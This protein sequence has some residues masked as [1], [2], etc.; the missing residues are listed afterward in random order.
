MRAHGLV[1]DVPGAGPADHL[2]WVYEDDAAFDEAAREFLAG[3]LARGERLLCVGQRM[4][5]SLRSVTD[6]VDTLIA[7]GVVETLT[8]ADAYEAS[9][10]FV[11]EQQLAYYDAATRRATD[12]GYRGLRVLA[13]V[14]DLAA[15][16]VQRADLVRWEHMADGFAAR[17]SGF[18]AMCAYRADLGSEALADVTAVHPLVHAPGDASSFRIF[19]DG[20]RIVLAGSVDTNSCDRLARVLAAA[21]PHDGRVVLDVA[22]L[23]FMDVSGCRVLARWAAD[24]EA[25]SVALEVTGSSALLRRMWQVLDLARLAPV[26][27]SGVSS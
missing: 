14:S 18:S 10:P 20:H 15:D 9:G 13:E 24:L 11:P 12:D 23:E 3:G 2:C 19:V 17:G 16:P 25:R 26:T 21:R 6:D 5:D 4:I 1:N 22:G 8:L 27:F 7:A